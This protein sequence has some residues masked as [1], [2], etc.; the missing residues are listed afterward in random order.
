M[1]KRDKLKKILRILLYAIT[2]LIIV[3]FVYRNA[4]QFKVLLDLRGLEIAIL[5]LVELFSIFVNAKQ[6]AFTLRIFEKSVSALEWFGLTVCNTLY[7]YI[8]PLKGGLV[9]RAYYLKRYHDFNYHNYLTL[10]TA[11]YIIN[12]WIASFLALA[13][14]MITSFFGDII[15]ISII[16]ITVAVFLSISLLSFYLLSPEKKESRLIKKLP[17]KIGSFVQKTISGFWYFRQNP[18]ILR[19]VI[20]YKILFILMLSLRLY[21]SFYMLGI[22]V[23][24]MKIVFVQCIIIYSMLIS[25]TPGNIGLKEGIIGFSSNL[26]EISMDEALAGAVLD[27]AISMVLIFLLGG[28]F[29]K[30]I[31]KDL[32]ISG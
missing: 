21:V 16:F 27:R 26:L 30:L 20:V 15:N 13:V 3:L 12:F 5:A 28:A 9:I 19:G 14:I 1:G 31:F 6:F 22:E 10:I 4:D 23:E 18:A 7:N 2:I 25:I 11:G 32:K 24:F 29:S 8:L 17:T